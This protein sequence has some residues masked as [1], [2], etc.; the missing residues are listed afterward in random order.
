[1]N[2]LIFRHKRI[3]GGRAGR[4]ILSDA[5]AALIQQLFNRAAITVLC[6]KPRTNQLHRLMLALMGWNDG[7]DMRLCNSIVEQID[8][9]SID[10]VY[11][12]GSN[13]G[14][15]A[16]FIKYRRPNCIVVTFFHN[17]EAK[18]FWDSFRTK[19]SLKSFGIA[20]FNYL[21]ERSAVRY[22]DR[23]ICLNDRDRYYLEKL[24][25]RRETDIIPMYIRAESEIEVRHARVTERE[26]AL[27]VGGAFY[28]NL[29][30]IR[31][32]AKNVAPFVNRRTI[33]I[34]QGFEQHQEELERF[35]NMEVV[36][37]VHSVAPWYRNAEFVVAP[38]FEGS[39]MKTK[40]AEAMMFGKPIAA[41]A[42]ALVGYENVVPEAANVCE[43]REE[44]IEAFSTFDDNG[45][46]ISPERSRELFARHYSEAA[47]KS[48][49]EELFKSIDE[50]SN[51]DAKIK[52]LREG[53]A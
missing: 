47:A 33:V 53:R 27:F 24:Y 48:R 32:F 19:W 21:A 10:V 36:G 6:R 41:T 49:F 51:L 43:D 8:K 2:I 18:F 37:A 45:W 34:G 1:M 12:D 13:F 15:L 9:Y 50:S 44:F 5:N 29:A 40:V 31:W 26:Y 14:R 11:I 22:S 30:G 3:D 4:E 23:V 25:G 38:I 52:R 17:V 42:E 35:P 39:G 16:R 20:V 28:A 46:G 7:L